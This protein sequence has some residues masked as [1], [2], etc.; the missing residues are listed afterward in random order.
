MKYPGTIL[1]FLAVLHGYRRSLEADFLYIIFLTVR[2][3]HNVEF[4]LNFILLFYLVTL[5]R[6]LLSI[7]SVKFRT[8]KIS[9]RYMVD[10]LWP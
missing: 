10:T 2:A 7:I 5:P 8:L 6:E 1:D 3:C 9:Q 4:L